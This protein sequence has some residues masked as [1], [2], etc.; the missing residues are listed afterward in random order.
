VA[1]AAHD[2]LVPILIQISDPECLDAGVASVEA[3][4][5]S[6]YNYWRPITAIL[7]A[8]SEGNPDTSAD[9]A[10]EP[11]ETTPPARSMT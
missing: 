2:V 11:L 7:L 5:K 6:R 3:E 10:W 8:D 4:T 1:T 9:P